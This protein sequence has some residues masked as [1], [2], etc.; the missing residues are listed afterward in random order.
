MAGWLRQGFH[1]LAGLRGLAADGMRRALERFPVTIA[2]LFGLALS[3]SLNEANLLD[4]TLTE[5]GATFFVVAALTSLALRL[6]AEAGPFARARLIEAGGALALGAIASVQSSADYIPAMIVG[7]LLLLIPAAA[8][9]SDRNDLPVVLGGL[10]FAAALGVLTLLIF[11]GGLSGTLASLRY[12]FG[13]PVP[14]RMFAQTWIWTGLF[15]APLF[16]LGRIPERGE[17]NLGG[18]ILL[19]RAALALFDFGAFP[20]LIVYTLVLHAYAAK[21][22]IAGELPRGQIGWMVLAYLLTLFGTLIVT[23]GHEREERPATSRFVMR[24]WPALVVGPMGLLFVS[25]YERVAAYGVTE[26]RYL[27]GLAGLVVLVWAVMQLSARFRND[28]RLLLLFGCTALIMASFGPWSAQSVS[29]SSQLSRFEASLAAFREGREEAEQQALGA[30]TYLTRADAV[31]RTVGEPLAVAESA[32][33]LQVYTR[34][35]GLDPDSRRISRFEG[36]HRHDSQ[37]M[38]LAGYDIMVRDVIV[39]DA[40]QRIGGSVTSDPPPIVLAA[41]EGGIVVTVGAQSATFAL[42]ADGQAIGIGE[43]FPPILDM[44]AGGR[45]IRLIVEHWS[46]SDPERDGSDALRRLHGSLLIRRADWR[47]LRR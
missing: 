17:V 28:H 24:Y 39:S 40:D 32:D 46:W 2:A 42:E 5:K 18:R 44:Q 15:L 3:V 34:H 37:M 7:A 30:L 38:D 10:G 22:A 25:L 16:A 11:A 20:L 36:F 14:D 21:I 47:A 13:L 6:A 4:D 41:R 43:P 35:F 9:R 26:E 27:L 12:L 33:T 8:S 29:V 31:E 23:A 45:R 1:S 19:D